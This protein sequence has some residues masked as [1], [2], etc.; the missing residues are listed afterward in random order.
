MDIDPPPQQ[1]APQTHDV[2][3]KTEE[4]AR[5]IPALQPPQPQRV[6]RYKDKFQSLR[7]RYENVT[8][9]HTEFTRA[10]QR[11]TEKELRLQAE[12]NMLLDAALATQP[13]SASAS[14]PPIPAAAVAA[15]A[16]AAGSAQSATTPT[17]VHAQLSPSD[18][19]AAL[20]PPPPPAPVPVPA[21]GL[22]AGP[23]HTHAHPHTNGHAS[24]APPPHAHSHGHGH[25]HA[26]GY[27][28]NYTPSVPAPGST[29]GLPPEIRGA[30]FSDR[31]A[32]PRPA[33]NM[34]P[35]TAHLTT[36][37]VVCYTSPTHNT[38]SIHT[39]I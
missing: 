19:Q 30:L 17:P 26:Q 24:L 29:H 12:I 1:H 9:T 34:P 15:A 6:Q 21:P 33:Q 35:T 38:A 14:T 23:P 39:N 3:I 13:Q 5:P 18:P 37:F 22:G 10:V 28:A 4:R 8:S 32:G 25:G 31:A 27:G 20:P 36:L 16:A 2:L 11:A 7:E